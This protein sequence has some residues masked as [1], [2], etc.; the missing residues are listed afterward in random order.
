MCVLIKTRGI[1][2]FVHGDDYVSTGLPKELNWLRE[3]LE[4]KYQ[5]KTQILGPEK[6]HMKEIRVLNRIITWNGHK[7]ITYE[8]DLRHVEIVIDQFKL[9]DAKLVCTPGTKEEGRTQ[10]DCEAPLEPKEASLFRA[11]VA[12]C[13][14]LSPD[15]PDI[16]YAVKELARQMS[17]PRKGDMQRLKRLGRC[18][19]GRPRLQQE[20]CWQNVQQTVKTFSDADWAGCRETRR[21]TTGGCITIGTHTIKSWS[22]T[23]SLVAL[24]SGESELYAALKASAETF[25]MLAI[26]NDFGWRL[27]G[28]VWGDAS[29][30]LGIINR[31]GLGKTRHIDTGCLWIQQVAVQQRSTF[32]KVLG[33]NNFAD[34]FTKHFEEK[35]N[36]LHTN[37][38]S[39][40]FKEGRSSEAPQLH[41]MSQSLDDHLHGENLEQW[42]WL[43]CIYHRL[44]DRCS[45]KQGGDHERVRRCDKAVMSIK[46]E[47]PVED[48]K[49]VSG[50]VV[51]NRRRQT[52]PWQQVLWG[53]TW[54]V[55]GYNGSNSAQ[56]S[57]PRGSTLIF[58]PTGGVPWELGLRY[59]VTMHPRGRHLREDRTL[60]PHGKDSTQEREQQPPHQ[61]LLLLP[62]R[63]QKMLAKKEEWTWR[64]RIEVECRAVSPHQPDHDKD[65]TA[66]SFRK[67][68][69]SRKP[70]DTN[71]KNFPSGVLGR[72]WFVN[73]LPDS[74]G[75][76]G[77]SEREEPKLRRENGSSIEHEDAYKDAKREECTRRDHHQSNSEGA[78]P[79]ED[80]VLTGPVRR[81]QKGRKKKIVMQK[82]KP[83][84]KGTHCR[85]ISAQCVSHHARKSSA[86]T[87][88]SHG[89]RG[90]GR[91]KFGQLE[92]KLKIVYT[93][94]R[95]KQLAKIL[96][97]K[98]FHSYHDNSGSRLHMSDCVQG[99]DISCAPIRMLSREMHPRG[100]ARISN[101]YT[102]THN[103][104]LYSYTLSSI[105]NG[106]IWG[107]NPRPNMYVVYVIINE[108]KLGFGSRLIC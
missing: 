47:D 5:V 54:Q 92:K 9:K 39:F 105:C 106:K 17:T 102:D 15:R 63:P 89:F 69:I 94:S 66:K 103:P 98:E 68:Q 100:G 64:R 13:N 38:L 79:L 88:K 48:S 90:R 6:E 10:D 12:R 30:A 16:S 43:Q 1:R 58:Q 28:E 34:L 19:K 21:S 37:D 23:Q 96:S 70:G 108:L 55:Q 25:G 50:Q 77:Q 33:T 31:Q 65:G 73:K 62:T 40:H 60:L 107:T 52:S 81:R 87:N 45:R 61:P 44:F 18:R 104:Y 95:A 2:T 36:R 57:H 49:C 74:H 24:S 29:A 71:C 7:R 42:E 76:V 3:Q 51:T 67:A 75:K 86:W 93:K 97:G 59:G 20:Y 41:K 85:A 72:I 80:E 35:V 11:I 8:A 99:F 84:L 46:R 4:G 22:R 91:C 82:R 27:R 32:H 26:M 56:L 53:Y 14:Y 101:V 78:K 83:I